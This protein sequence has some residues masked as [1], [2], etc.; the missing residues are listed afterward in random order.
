MPDEHGSTLVDAHI[1]LKGT[2][3]AN[4]NGFSMIDI[5]FELNRRHAYSWFRMK[6]SPDNCN[7][8]NDNNSIIKYSLSH[9][10]L[11][12]RELEIS[13]CTEKEFL[14][15]DGAGVFLNPGDH[16]FKL[17]INNLPPN[18]GYSVEI[19][20]W[21]DQS[22]LANISKNALL[23]GADEGIEN[24]ICF[25]IS[26]H[27]LNS[28][29]IYSLNSFFF[30][31]KELENG[32]YIKLTFPKNLLWNENLT[33]YLV[34]IDESD[35]VNLKTTPKLDLYK[36]KTSTDPFAS[37][38]TRFT[39]EIRP[40]ISR[41]TDEYLEF[42][43]RRASLEAS[44]N[45]PIYIPEEF[46]EFFPNEADFD[47]FINEVT[48]GISSGDKENFLGDT[49]L[50]LLDRII[51]PSSWRDMG[52]TEAYFKKFYY[53]DGY[54]NGK[55]AGFLVAM[56]SI[57]TISGCNE[58]NSIDY[59]E[60]NHSN[61]QSNIDCDIE[62][63]HQRFGIGVSQDAINEIVKPYHSYIVPSGYNGGGDLSWAVSYWVKSGI[64][65]IQITNKG[66]DVSIP[67][68]EGGGKL[69][70]KY[71][72]RGINWWKASAALTMRF[73]DVH[74]SFSIYISDDRHALGLGIKIDIGDLKVKFEVHND[75]IFALAA[76]LEANFPTDSIVA[77]INTY[78]S[79]TL[80]DTWKTLP[81]EGY[82]FQEIELDWYE[83]ESVIIEL[84]IALD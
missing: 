59:T 82:K 32:M 33:P 74:I 2:G 13:P 35:G 45:T 47:T 78:L 62:Y 46:K 43:L 67:G 12:T 28:L 80:F 53:K 49:L 20:V 15:N 5:P 27:L 1:E 3:L 6:I 4:A 63:L 70:A 42:H 31:E 26:D 58:N 7:A 36:N 48:G 61:L 69:D 30:I 23:E 60:N 9:D 52:K 66:F 19:N 76:S 34:Q 22:D 83:D 81:E 18:E 55:R 75:H 41:G 73:E 72:T 17:T 21:K 51:I 40:S 71:R 37:I 8:I 79:L 39:L 44:P 56:F 68:I 11:S 10:C 77:L 24:G 38:E 65:N 25:T 16:I 14:F 29:G 64:D 57:Y 54:I 50:I 84:G